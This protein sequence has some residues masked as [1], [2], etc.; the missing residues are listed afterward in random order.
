MIDIKPIT[1]LFYFSVF[2]TMASAQNHELSQRTGPVETTFT[3]DSAFFSAFLSEFT[4]RCQQYDT[5][6][7]AAWRNNPVKI[8]LNNKYENLLP[9]MP[10]FDI[11]PAFRIDCPNGHVLGMYNLL[12]IHNSQT[13]IHSYVQYLDVL[14]YTPQGRLVSRLSLCLFYTNS[15][16]MDNS[17]TRYLYQIIGNAD[18]MNGEIHYGH[19]Q[20]RFVN[21]ELITHSESTYVYKIQDDAT[22]KLLSVD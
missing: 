7:S 11:Y 21:R 6:W 12:S 15:Y 17:N 4:M 19:D 5:L 18:I 3:Q 8:P 2:V 14:S 20:R 22:L 9:T 16:V 10:L 13:K 1:I